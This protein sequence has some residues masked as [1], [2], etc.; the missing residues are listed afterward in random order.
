MIKDILKVLVKTYSVA[1]AVT[2]IALLILNVISSQ[3][4]KN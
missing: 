1:L 4:E 2:G 3:K